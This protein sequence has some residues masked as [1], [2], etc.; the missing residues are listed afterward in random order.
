MAR[1]GR[2]RDL[3]LFLVVLPFW[4]SFLVRTFAMI[5]LLRDSGLVNT[6][7]LRLGL[8]EAPL[9][10]LYT[11]SRQPAEPVLRPRGG[12]RHQAELAG[13]A[14]RSRGQRTQATYPSRLG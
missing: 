9:T 3:L 11:P 6:V 1:S 10:L 2:W 4:T 14:T 5:F 8:I 7:L 12:P 13:R